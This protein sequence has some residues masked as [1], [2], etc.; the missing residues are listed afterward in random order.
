MFECLWPLDM[1]QTITYV[2]EVLGRPAAECI[3]L[4]SIY[5]PPDPPIA[6]VFGM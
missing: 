6:Q 1:R 3:Y 4:A 2:K 5:G